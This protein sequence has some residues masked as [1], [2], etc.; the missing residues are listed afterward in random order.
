VGPFTLAFLGAALC[1]VGRGVTLLGCLAVALVEALEVA[2]AV[3]VKA[4]ASSATQVKVRRV[5]KVT[6]V[7]Q[8]L[9]ARPAW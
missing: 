6:R 5:E 9:N 8:G 3:D 7:C 4:V 2:F 1:L